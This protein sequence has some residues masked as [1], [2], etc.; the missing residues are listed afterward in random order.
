MAQMI[1]EKKVLDALVAAVCDVRF[2]RYLFARIATEETGYVRKRLLM[3]CTA[4]IEMYAISGDYGSFD[5]DEADVVPLAIRL[6]DEVLDYCYSLQESG[7]VLDFYSEAE[8][9]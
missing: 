8:V 7:K 1:I 6:R 2:S 3:L 5:I 9:E 4:F